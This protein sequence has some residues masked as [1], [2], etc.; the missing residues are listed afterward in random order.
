MKLYLLFLLCVAIFTIVWWYIVTLIIIKKKIE[1]KEKE[2]RSIFRERT[3]LIPS[4]YEVTKPHIE[5]HSFAFREILYLR[6]I[7][8]LNWDSYRFYE[9]INLESKI[10]HELEFLFQLFSKSPKLEKNGNFLYLKDQAIEVSQKI[11]EEII[12]YK[13]MIGRYNNLLI[14]KNLTIIGLLF[15]VNKKHDIV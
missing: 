8:Y 13:F 2:I 3:N 14:Y 6:K 10:H 9:F 7:E 12:I 1:Q 5:R 11:W 4:L 15:P